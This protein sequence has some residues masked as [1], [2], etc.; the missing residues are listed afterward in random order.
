MPSAPKKSC[1]KKTPLSPEEQALVIQQRREA[2]EMRLL[3]L[4]AK[5]AK[6]RALLLKYTT[7]QSVEEAGES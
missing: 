7:P 6:D 1:T 4:E 3:K 5:I 2:I